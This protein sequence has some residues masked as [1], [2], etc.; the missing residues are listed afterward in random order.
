MLANESA[1][2]WYSKILQNDKTGNLEQ[3]ILGLR[4]I[5][6]SLLL[7]M[8]PNRSSQ[9]FYYSGIELIF[10]NIKSTDKSRKNNELAKKDFHKLRDYLNSIQ[11]S[12]IEADNLGYITCIK[13]LVSL[14]QFCSDTYPPNEVK[15][16]FTNKKSEKTIVENHSNNTSKINDKEKSSYIFI[17]DTNSLSYNAMK[18]IEQGF[19][20]LNETFSTDILN[21]EVYSIGEKS[22]KYTSSILSKQRI[23]NFNTDNILELMK[24]LS[25]IS[26]HKNINLIK[27]S[28][29]FLLSHG[30]VGRLNNIDINSIFKNRF[31]YHLFIHIDSTPNKIMHERDKCIESSNLPDFFDWVKD[32]INSNQ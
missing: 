16:L 3:K 29:C 22:A 19:N 12:K 7:E 26:A 14:I 9:D 17:I 8:F 32:F 10:A 5:F 13:R 1:L 25:D 15:L 28:V 2:T 4:L 11:H 23:F 21:I 30:S 27:N 20:L 24:P 6:D 18:Y 31:K